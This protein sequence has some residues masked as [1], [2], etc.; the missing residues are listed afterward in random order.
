MTYEYGVDC[1]SILYMKLD[2]RS[3][4][5]FVKIFNDFL[6]HFFLKSGLKVETIII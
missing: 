3:L 1:A 4:I 2:T 6:L 5:S